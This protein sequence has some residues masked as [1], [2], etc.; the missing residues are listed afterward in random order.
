MNETSEGHYVDNILTDAYV[1]YEKDWQHDEYEHTHQRYQL[2]FVEE[3]YQYFHIEEKIYL[4]PQNHVIWIPSSK[5]H[6]TTSEAK[7]V[8]L[9]LLLFRTVPELDFYRKVHVFS[10]PAVLREMLLYASKWSKLLNEGEE[11]CVFIKAMLH[12]LPYFCEENSSL[13]IP[14]PAD[15]RLIPV[16]NHI[17]TNYQYKFQIDKLA[18]MAKMSVRSLQRIFKQQTGISLQKYTQLIRILKSIELMD[19][20]QYTL[21]QIAALVGYKSL[22]AFTFS[23][24][25]IMKTGP[26][27][28]K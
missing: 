5:V 21:S 15:S 19:T 1:W 22:S 3:G 17:N 16:C 11:K 9:M 23:Y 18:D 14:A 27:L 20:N 26:K 2:T 28:K 13:Q 24:S 7:T 12:S 25:S 8:N 10:A 6:R 4:V